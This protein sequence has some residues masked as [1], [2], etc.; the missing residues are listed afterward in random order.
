[1]KTILA[2]CL[3]LYKQI[4]NLTICF[5]RQYTEFASLNANG[6]INYWACYILLVLL[7]FS[8][9]VRAVPHECVIRTSHP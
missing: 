2:Q 1:M 8:L 4:T 5:T 7:D 3:C 6:E 9:T